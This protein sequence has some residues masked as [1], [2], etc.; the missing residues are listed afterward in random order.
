MDHNVPDRPGS[1]K[2][3]HLAQNQIDLCAG[4]AETI[5]KALAQIAAHPFIWT[6]IQPI[7]RSQPIF[8]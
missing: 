2:Q 5:G 1:A 4:A 7:F 3:S 8:S 6:D